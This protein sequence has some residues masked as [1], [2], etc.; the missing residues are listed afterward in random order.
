V[1]LETAAR[2]KAITEQHGALFLLNDRPD[3]AVQAD[4]DGVHVGQDDVPADQARA[5]IGPDRILGL[6]THTAQDVDGVRTDTIDY[7]GVGP[8]YATPTKPGRAAVGNELVS[9]A[10][11]HASVPFFAIGGINQRNVE[12]VIAAGATRLA[13]VRAIADAEDPLQAARA[14]KSEVTVGAA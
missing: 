4:A 11:Q 12:A 9:Y 13:V 5:V 6:S 14:L 8:V 10:A 2:F 7:I 1:I 3:L